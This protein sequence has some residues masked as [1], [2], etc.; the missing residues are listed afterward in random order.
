MPETCKPEESQ[1]AESMGD[2]PVDMHPGKVTTCRSVGIPSIH[3]T[4]YEHLSTGGTYKLT[5]AWPARAQILKSSRGR[6]MTCGDAPN[7]VRAFAV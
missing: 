5:P 6:W 2:V 3:W 4:G 1:L 7:L